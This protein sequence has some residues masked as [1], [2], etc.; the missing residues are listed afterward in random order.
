MSRLT[1]WT[2]CCLIVTFSILARDNEAPFRVFIA[3]YAV[4][5]APLGMH[6]SFERW[7]H[8]D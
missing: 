1:V 6:Y 7:I 4:L 8:H 3:F 2:I 5:G